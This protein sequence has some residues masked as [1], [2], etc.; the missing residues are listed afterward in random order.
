[1][2]VVVLGAGG[3]A[4]ASALSV[5]AP[6]YETYAA[7]L[8]LTGFC[9]VTTLT[10]AN[11]YVQTTTDP[12]LRGRVLALY[13]AILLGGTPVGAPI[14]GAVAAEFGPRTAIALAAGVALVACGIGVT[15]TLA[16][17]RVH[18]HDTKAIPPHDRRDPAD[19]DRDARAR[20]LQRRDRRDHA[21]PPPAGRAART[22]HPP[23]AARRL[24]R[25]RFAAVTGDARWRIPGGIRTSPDQGGRPGRGS[26]SESE[27][28]TTPFP[29]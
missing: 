21:H 3:F 24:T 29:R 17:G 19:R 16:S 12:A 1:M 15:W 14:V 2:R 23:P 25:R 10:T 5:L 7:T 20:G 11:G 28:R 27:S 18:R 4:V 6:S 26:V 8:V 9:V 13:M 22:R